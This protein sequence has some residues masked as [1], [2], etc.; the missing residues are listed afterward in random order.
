MGKFH[1]KT[2]EEADDLLSQSMPSS[3][4]AIKPIKSAA[5]L[6]AVTLNGSKDAI[7]EKVNIK[8]EISEKPPAKKPKKAE[9]KPV[10][11]PVNNA[12]I[13]PKAKIELDDSDPDKISCPICTKLWHK[14]NLRFVTGPLAVPESRE[15]IILII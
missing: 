9:A 6:P 10:K 12:P 1:S 13:E 8:T 7:N 15:S 4:R 2:A 11:E 14:S 3:R 5:P